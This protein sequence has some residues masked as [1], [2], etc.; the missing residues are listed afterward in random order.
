MFAARAMK[1]EVGVKH[2]DAKQME[3]AD[4]GVPPLTAPSLAAF[5]SVS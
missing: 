5:I 2:K 4:Q 3:E 1:K